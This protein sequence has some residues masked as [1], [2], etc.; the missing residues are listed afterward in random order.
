MT[1]TKHC[2]TLNWRQYYVR[3][4]ESAAPSLHIFGNFAIRDR[5][6]K[7]D[8]GA[9]VTE[10][11]SP[12][13]RVCLFIWRVDG[14]FSSLLLQ[15]MSEKPPFPNLYSLK[16]VSAGSAAACTV[17]YR[18]SEAV[19]LSIDK[20]DWFHVCETHLKDKNFATLIYADDSGKVNSGEWKTLCDEVVK[21]AGKIKVAEKKAK[22]KESSVKSW[23]TWSGKGKDDDG[24]KAENG[25]NSENDAAAS[26]NGGGDDGTNGKET[27]ADLRSQ[28]KLAEEKLAAFEKVNIKYTLQSSFY[29]SRLLLEWN[30][31]KAA[32]TRAKLTEGTLFPSL[33]GLA[34]LKG[35]K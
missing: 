15:P 4:C 21:C 2:E 16:H 28:H 9:L 34:P 30:R 27:L 5:R 32:E 8:G 19:L 11:T 18:P 29:K 17:C 7:T 20:K 3:V 26:G 12:H 10:V 35:E 31:R 14:V 24:K 22:D 25:K 6:Q 1:P 13:L 33:E 23:L